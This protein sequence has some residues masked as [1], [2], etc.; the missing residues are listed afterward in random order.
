MMRT[1]NS[2]MRVTLPQPRTTGMKLGL[3]YHRK[4][5]KLPFIYA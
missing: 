3:L 4:I 5:K 2:L 1:G